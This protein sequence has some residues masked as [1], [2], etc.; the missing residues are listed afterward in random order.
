M[1]QNKEFNYNSKFIWSK[2]EKIDIVSLK[3]IIENYLTSK[4][5]QRLCMYGK[6]YESQNADMVKRWE[7]RKKRNKLPNNFIPTAYYSTIVD[8][9][10]GY[11]FQNVSYASDNE[12]FSSTLNELLEINKVSIKDMIT[13]VRALAFNKAIE[14]IY[15]VGDETNTEIKFVSI[16][17][18]QAIMIYNSK[19]EPEAI[20]GIVINQSYNKDY[21]YMIDVIYADEWQYYWMKNNVISEREKPR[22]LLFKECPVVE[23]KTEILNDNSSFHSIIP[24]IDAL[25]Y[26]VSGNANEI[27]RLVDALLILGKQ[28]DDEQLKH[29]DEWKI[30]QDMKMDDRAEYI[31][32]DLSPIFREYVS[33]LLIQEIHKHSHVIDWYSPDSGLTGAVS[34]KALQTRLFDMNMYSQ[35]IEKIFREGAE[36]RIRII[37]D[38]MNIKNMEADKCK[39]IYNRT[40]PNDVEDKAAILNNVTFIDDQTKIELCGLDWSTIKERMDAQQ[41]EKDDR[42]QKQFLELY[43]N[44]NNQ[45]KSNNQQNTDEK[46]NQNVDNKTKNINDLLSNQRIEK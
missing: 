6:Y 28:V 9:M 23:Y 16:D 17:P 32:K 42:A 45:D 1:I 19:I 8:S 43:R 37:T 33:K 25:D 12:E 44:K 38:L 15:T 30:L 7:D 41:K 18:R 27:E 29:M 14:L 34:A 21:D 4:E 39:I 24:Y 46:V 11:M 35:R 2:P 13:G 10:A 3:E 26:I 22:V 40:L 31:G 36:K 20:C 5:Y